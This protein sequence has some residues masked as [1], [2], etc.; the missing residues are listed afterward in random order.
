VKELSKSIEFIVKAKGSSDAQVAD[1][2]TTWLEKLW[3]ERTPSNGITEPRLE[4]TTEKRTTR[5]SAGVHALPEGDNVFKH[6]KNSKRSD[7]PSTTGLQTTTARQE[8]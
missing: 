8:E 1:E 4:T 6:T 3:C 2:L 5:P 7:G